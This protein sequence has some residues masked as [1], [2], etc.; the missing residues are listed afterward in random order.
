MKQFNDHCCLSP[1]CVWLCDPMDCSTLGLSFP[2][3]LPKFAQV[4]CFCDAIQPSCPLMGPLLSSIFPRIRDF[5]NESAVHIRWPKYWS[6]SFSISP[7]TEY[8]ELISLK[9]DLFDLLAVQ[10]TLRS[11]LMITGSILSITEFT[12]S[13][14][15]KSI[16]VH[17]KKYVDLPP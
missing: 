12:I 17:Y 14:E 7:S 11:P 13:L 15:P 8:S 2:H 4:R 3:H 10:G 16:W 9:I 6:L 5:P 1:S